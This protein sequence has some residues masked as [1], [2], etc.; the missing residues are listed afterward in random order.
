MTDLMTVTLQE[1]GQTLGRRS[2]ASAGRVRGAA[3]GVAGPTGKDA[4]TAGEGRA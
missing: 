1:L 2:A 3:A 4:K